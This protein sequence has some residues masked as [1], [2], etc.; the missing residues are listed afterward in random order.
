MKLTLTIVG[1]RN[2]L[3]NGAADYPEL[4]ARMPIGTT[5]YLRREPTGSKYPGSIS[6]WDEECNQIGNV[7]KT[8]RRYIELDIVQDEMLPV[9]I[10]G[11]SAEHNCMYFEAENKNGV[12]QPYIR[13]VALEEGE[14]VFPL[15]AHDDRLLKLTD[16]MR[17]KLRRLDNASTDNAASLL[18]TARQ[19]SEMCCSSLDGET[20]FNRADILIELRT[21]KN[22][23]S[24]LSPVYS[25]IFESH[26]DIGRAQNDVKTEVYR[27]QYQRIRQE[28]QQTDAEGLSPLDYYI[29]DLKFRH[30][31]RLDTTTID[32]EI[33]HLSTLLARELENSYIANKDSDEG[34]A[35]A[36]YSLN[37]SLQ[38][39]YRMFTR[40]IKLDRLKEIKQGLPL[41]RKK[42]QTAKKD[43]PSTAAPTYPTFCYKCPNEATKAQ[44]LSII[45]L[46]MQQWRWIEEPRTAN[47]FYDLFSGE[48]RFCNIRW[49]G[50]LTVLTELTKQ[51]LNGPRYMERKKGVSASAIIKKQF[52]KNRSS[53]VERLD[54]DS[55]MQIRI[56]LGILDYNQP[57][58]DLYQDKDSIYDLNDSVLF[59][60][61]SGNMRVTKG[62]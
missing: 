52:E 35:S 11:H 33:L 23:Y 36:L 59:D 15:T 19:Y 44:R 43:T 53:N 9:T 5:V 29:E 47:D 40:R 38:A 14:T 49:I 4:F 51:L 25:A 21:L 8:E 6:V 13:Q 31:D 10:S 26:K 27:N 32:Q 20:S 57:L 2:Y 37:Y 61:F 7:S 62:I 60:V 1:I 34:F 48:D 30:G 17:T 24:E 42:P 22:K 3:P 41:P 18:T 28:A 56:I 45:M 46:K 12:K 58:T 16:M 50:G 39:I 54:N 55:R